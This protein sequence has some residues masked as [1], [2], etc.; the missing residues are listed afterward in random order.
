[1]SDGTEQIQEAAEPPVSKTSVKHDVHVHETPAE[2]WD[3]LEAAFGAEGTA[4][5]TQWI[6]F[7]VGNA[8]ANFYRPRA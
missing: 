1:M 8:R 3:A 4:G 5:S 6:T 2:I 7:E